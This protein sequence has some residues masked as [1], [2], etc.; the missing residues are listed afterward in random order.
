MP[1]EPNRENVLEIASRIARRFSSGATNIHMAH[2]IKGEIKKLGLTKDVNEIAAYVSAV[3]SELGRR[4]NEMRPRKPVT[5]KP[6]L[7]LFDEGE[8]PPRRRRVA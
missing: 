1:W 5:E 2:A 6:Q 7:D 3:T 8:E 4:G